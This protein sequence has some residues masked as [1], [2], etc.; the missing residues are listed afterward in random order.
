MKTVAEQ[1]SYW[2]SQKILVQE[3]SDITLYIPLLQSLEGSEV[4]I[5]I[6]TLFLNKKLDNILHIN[7]ILFCEYGLY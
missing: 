1:S 3:F 5:L 6:N 2:V 4:T 7:K